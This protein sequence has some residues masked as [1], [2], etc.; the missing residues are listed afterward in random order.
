ML[1]YILSFTFLASIISLFLVSIFLLNKKLISKFS[2]SL[3]S[4][5]AGALL[6][7][8]FMDTLKEAVEMGGENVYLWVTFSVGGFFLVERIFHFLHH[9]DDEDE[10]EKLKIP[11]PFLLFG[12]GMHNFID[13]ISIA[14][15]FLVS[16]PLGIVT[17]LAVFIHEIPH[18]LGDFGI[19]L[20]KGWGRG[21][22]LKFN[23]ATGLTSI[24]GALLAFYLGTSFENIVPIL[25]SITTA[26]F[27]YLSTTNLLPEIHNKAKKS[28]ALGDVIFFFLGIS[29][30]TVLIKLLG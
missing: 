10:E 18:E 8:A 20:H 1:I 12:D 9:H 3:V 21:K 27:I 13:G 24:I 22:V 11:I 2:F 28:L 29:F 5:G 4:F 14:S 30:V 26:N 6:A 23:I 15:S 25:L 19:L 17:S 16:V 7:A